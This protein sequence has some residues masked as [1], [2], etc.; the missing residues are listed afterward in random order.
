MRPGCEKNTVPLGE[1][2]QIV[3]LAICVWMATA[4]HAPTRHPTQKNSETQFQP[5]A[6]LTG[7]GGFR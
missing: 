3:L 7:A 1:F 5:K 6:K 2:E 4:G